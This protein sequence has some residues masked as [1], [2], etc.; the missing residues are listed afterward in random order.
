MVNLV[1]PENVHTFS[2]VYVLPVGIGSKQRRC[3]LVLV[4]SFQSR[5]DGTRAE[6]TGEVFELQTQQT[7]LSSSWDALPA[8]ERELDG[9]GGIV[10]KL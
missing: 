7:A 4:K 9:A 1:G 6:T 8:R 10:L 2:S 3:A 5:G